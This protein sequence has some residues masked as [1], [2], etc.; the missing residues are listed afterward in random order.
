[1]MNDIY[2]QKAE[3]STLYSIENVILNLI[4]IALRQKLFS[5]VFK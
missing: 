3:K 2:A 5:Q 4:L 1:M